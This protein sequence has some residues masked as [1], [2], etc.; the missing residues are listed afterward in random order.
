MNQLNTYPCCLILFFAYVVF[1]Q[2]AHIS[3]A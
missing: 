2:I 3:N 1:V